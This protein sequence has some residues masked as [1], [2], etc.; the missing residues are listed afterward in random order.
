MDDME[1]NRGG[2]GS[3]ADGRLS[4]IA[5]TTACSRPVGSPGEVQRELMCRIIVSSAPSQSSAVSVPDSRERSSKGARSVLDPSHCY[6]AQSRTTS[7]YLISITA[8]V[9]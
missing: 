3:L 2:F 8:N 1:I 4:Q 6:A 9:K 5:F 7:W